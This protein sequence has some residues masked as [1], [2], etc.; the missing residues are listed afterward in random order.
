M[1]NSQLINIAKKALQEEKKKRQQ[2][3]QDLS[4]Q[5]KARQDVYLDYASHRVEG[6][7]YVAD[8]EHREIPAIVE[9]ADRE[10]RRENKWLIH[11]FEGLSVRGAPEPTDF[12]PQIIRSPFEKDRD[13]YMEKIVARNSNTV[14]RYAENLWYAGIVK[15]L[16]GFEVPAAG[17]TPPAADQEEEKEKN[18][19]EEEAAGAQGPAATEEE[20]EKEAAG[21]QGPAATQGEGG[22]QQ[23]PAKMTIAEKIAAS[24]AAAAAA[25]KKKNN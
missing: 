24:A 11:K 12:F 4:N 16:T 3:R 25:A 18:E 20:K 23:Q 15:K 6:R 17:S 10:A 8:P 7:P 21:A 22:E 2:A 13:H 5:M 1:N 9:W 14:R 19:E